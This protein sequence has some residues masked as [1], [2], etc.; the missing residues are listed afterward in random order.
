MTEELRL[1]YTRGKPVRG[2]LIGVLF[3]SFLAHRAARHRSDLARGGFIEK[4]NDA[5][6]VII[7]P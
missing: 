3:S 2:D 6:R 4:Y 5:A 1:I 7:S